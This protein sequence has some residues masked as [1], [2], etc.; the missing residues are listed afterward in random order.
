MWNEFH[1][2]QLST[3]ASVDILF[4]A[5]I[6]IQFQA[7][8]LLEN[9]IRDIKVS[10]LENLKGLLRG[11]SGTLLLY[12]IYFLVS[13]GSIS[14]MHA[15]M[16]GAFQSHQIRNILV[17]IEIPLGVLF[18]LT[19]IF[20]ISPV[21]IRFTLPCSRVSDPE[22]RRILERCFQMA[23]SKFPP[24]GFCSWSDRNPIMPWW[25]ACLGGWDGFVRRFSLL[26]P[27]GQS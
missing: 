21:F 15:L 1:S 7:V 16:E 9:E 24:S 14:G 18:G 26:S 10:R 3:P 4:L 22:I 19:V 6:L 11:L 2:V 27:F 23:S 13:V 20:L 5:A 17:W 8:A 25:P 12:T